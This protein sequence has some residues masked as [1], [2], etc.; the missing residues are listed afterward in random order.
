MIK[1]VYQEEHDCE[2]ALFNALY[3]LML[4]IPIDKITVTQLT[5]TAHVSRAGFYRRYRDKYDLLNRSYEKIL[6]STLFTF[7]TGN[8]WRDS[9]YQIYSVI[10]E[11][12]QF[13]RNAF[14]STDFNSLSNYIFDRTL[15]LEKEVLRQNGV[16][17]EDP[18]NA[19]RLVG[20]VSGGL[21]VTKKW[22]DDRA[23][24]PLEQLVDIFTEM[25][26]SAFREYFR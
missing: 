21:A 15:R 16:D 25:V 6:E 22:V 2:Q 10:G 18:A 26:P 13:F 8:T 1:N 24:Y 9:I 12:W 17:P 19:Y 4:S 11:H 23:E 3:T 14:H 5:E 20:Y 7:H